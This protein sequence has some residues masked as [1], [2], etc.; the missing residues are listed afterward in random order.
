MN[1]I[2]TQQ[3]FLSIFKKMSERTVTRNL[4]VVAEGERGSLTIYSDPADIE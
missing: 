2:K 3:F 4:K 1:F